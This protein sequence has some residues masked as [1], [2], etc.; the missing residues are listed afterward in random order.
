MAP[1][2]SIASLESTWNL[3]YSPTNVRIWKL[4]LNPTSSKVA[5]P[6]WLCPAHSQMLLISPIFDFYLLKLL[7]WATCYGVDII[8][9]QKSK[10]Q[11]LLFVIYV[12]IYEKLLFMKFWAAKDIWSQYMAKNILASWEYLKHN[13]NNVKY[14]D[15]VVT[16]K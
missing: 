11:D 10:T 5:N 14:K 8:I 16:K 12:N 3:I 1:L 13:E 2:I 9:T 7:L 6:I 4:N 15:N